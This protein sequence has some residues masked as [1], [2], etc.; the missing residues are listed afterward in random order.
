M[1]HLLFHLGP[2]FALLV[3]QLRTLELYLPLVRRYAVLEPIHELL[4]IIIMNKLFDFLIL[5]FP[6]DLDVI[7]LLPDG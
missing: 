1:R 3:K 2:R 7:A 6:H 5:H 4:G